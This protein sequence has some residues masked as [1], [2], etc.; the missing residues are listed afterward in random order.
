MQRNGF[1][2]EYDVSALTVAL[3]PSPLPFWS[4]ASM[5]SASSWSTV[6]HSDPLKNRNDALASLFLLFGA[7]LQ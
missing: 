4:L 3:H 1:R 2:K 7:I 6:S 5:I